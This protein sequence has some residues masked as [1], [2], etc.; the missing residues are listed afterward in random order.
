MELI[1]ARDK[2]QF[3]DPFTDIV[4]LNKHSILNI[5]AKFLK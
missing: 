2:F 3:S 1:I 5:Y 4:E